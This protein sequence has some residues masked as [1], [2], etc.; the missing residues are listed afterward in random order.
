MAGR[1][2]P[3]QSRRRRGGFPAFDRCSAKRVRTLAVGFRVRG[4][5]GK[6]LPEHPSIG[7]EKADEADATSS[8]DA[9][10]P[11]GDEPQP[12]GST[13]GKAAATAA[14][15]GLDGSDD[16]QHSQPS[17]QGSGK[18]EGVSSVGGLPLVHMGCWRHRGARGTPGRFLSG[19]RRVRSKPYGRR[20]VR[21]GTAYSGSATAPAAWRWRI[22]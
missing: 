14:P 19:P 17:T 8:A 6:R 9:P 15:K 10:A 20:G 5:M 13:R 11:S 18:G 1:P 12:N 7:P 22:A 16:E 3:S 21:H 4:C 2:S